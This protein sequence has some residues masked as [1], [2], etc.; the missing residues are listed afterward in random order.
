MRFF[1]ILL[2]AA[3]ATSVFGFFGIA[4]AAEKT[5]ISWVERALIQPGNFEIHAKIDTG[6]KT[7]SL[8]APN[9]KI[10]ERDGAEWAMFEVTNRAGVTQRFEEKIFRIAKIRRHGNRYQK[11]PV[12]MLGVCVG[13]FYKVTQVNLIDRKNFNYQM[14][15]GRRFMEKHLIVDPGRT[16]IAKPKCDVEAKTK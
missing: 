8:N 13:S 12:I 2:V 4:G 6:A 16:F 1:V 14:L 9:L 3:I 10:V 11:R 5:V 15:I 7:S